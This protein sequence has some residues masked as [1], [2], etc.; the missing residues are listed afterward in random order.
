MTIKK[1]TLIVML[2]AWIITGVLWYV[3]E[4]DEPTHKPQRR[5]AAELNLI[6]DNLLDSIK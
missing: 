3:S 2:A 5:P 6:A 1:A 4:T